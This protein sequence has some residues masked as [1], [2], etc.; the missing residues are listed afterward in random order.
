M[1]VDE[2]EKNPKERRRARK[3]ERTAASFV[4]YSRLLY[5]FE[6]VF[7]IRSNLQMDRLIGVRTKL[8]KKR[9]RII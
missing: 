3:R 5:L 9:M 7:Q 6:Y 8:D 4:G 1:D 2:K